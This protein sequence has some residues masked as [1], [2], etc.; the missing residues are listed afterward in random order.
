MT[1]LTAT[2]VK[3]T[4]ES[5][6]A[7]IKAITAFGDWRDDLDRNGYAIIKGAVPQER[8]VKYQ[9][10]AFEW[11]S[12]FGTD[13]NIN[14]PSTW[15]TANLPVQSKINIFTAYCV[16]H[17]KF[18]WDARLEPGVV[19]AFTKLWGTDELLV[20]FDAPNITLPNRA[21][22]PR[23]GAWAHVD[24][25]PFRR[26]RVCVQGII[27]LSHSGPSDGSLIV[28]PGSH[29]L[30]EE[31]FD[32]HVAQADWTRRDLYLFSEAELAWFEARGA[33]PHK[34]CAE[35]GDLLVWDSRTVH[36]GAEPEPES[37]T[38]RTVIYASYAPAAWASEEALREKAKIWRHWGGTTHWPHDNVVFRDTRARLP[39]GSLDPRN[40]SEPREKPDISDRLLKLAGA[41]RYDGSEVEPAE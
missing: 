8:A 12:S 41:R 22:K 17:E 24:Q 19:D 35:P 30:T 9:K 29:R 14:D 15:T 18:M 33:K 36:W 4:Q 1:T 34:I 38:I 2:T 40:R 20:S 7:T 27:N 10:K 25:S 37:D 16:S 6:V 11:L 3:S 13:F 5:D 28:Y 39:D 21:D 26:G 23:N 32:T 31:F